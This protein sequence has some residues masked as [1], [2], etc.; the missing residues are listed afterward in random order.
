M[1]EFFRENQVDHCA[2]R[3]MQWQRDSIKRKVLDCGSLSHYK[4]PSSALISRIM[5]LRQEENKVWE[6]QGVPREGSP[7][8]KFM[9]HWNLDEQAWKALSELDVSSRERVR[10]TFHPPMETKNPSAVFMTFVKSAYAKGR[11]VQ[12]GWS[13]RWVIRVQG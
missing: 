3:K 6:E 1:E 4:N 8:R 12:N 10:S 7:T 9:D 11:S 2:R 13:N 5:D